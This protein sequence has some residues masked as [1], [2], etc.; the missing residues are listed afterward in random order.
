M[1]SGIG[2]YRDHTGMESTQKKIREVREKCRSV[3]I[4]DKGK[5][6]NTELVFNLEL[7]FMINFAEAVCAGAIARTE[8]RGAHFRTDMKERDDQNWLKHTV[9]Y[10][11]SGGTRVSTTPVKITKWQP[12]TRVY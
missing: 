2:V 12:E 4:G 7:E 3:S 1:T 6:F 11:V 8:S 9:I 10:K 5:V